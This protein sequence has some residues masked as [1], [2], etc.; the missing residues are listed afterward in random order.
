VSSIYIDTS[1]LFAALVHN[2]RLHGD[3]KETMARLLQGNLVLHMTSYGLLET[4]A[5]LQSRVSLGAARQ[6]E[7][8]IRPLFEI[9]WIDERLHR[10]AF[11]RLEQRGSRNVSLVDCAGFVV[12]EMKGIRSVFGYDSHFRDEGFDLIRTS[13]DLG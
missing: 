9:T 13:S 11:R 7:E 4:L 5:L 2:D 12:M 8:V 1:G 10:Q 3:A 6:V